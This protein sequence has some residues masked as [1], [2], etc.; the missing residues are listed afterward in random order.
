MKHAYLH[1]FVYIKKKT[2]WDAVCIASRDLSKR[3]TFCC[4][5]NG[6]YLK[7][8][9]KYVH[10]SNAHKYLTYCRTVI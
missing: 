3:H 6:K 7:E 2:N 5:S 1:K 4:I 9:S 8:I 10:I